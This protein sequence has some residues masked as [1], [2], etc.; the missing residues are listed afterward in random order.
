MD[1]IYVEYI[2]NTKV[3]INCP[4][5]IRKELTAEYSFYIPNHK[6]HPLVK[7][8]RW[9]G[10]IYLFN[11][12]QSTL[13]VGLVPDLVKLVSSRGYD[14]ELSTE[15]ANCFNDDSITHEW[16]AKFISQIPTSDDGVKITARDYQLRMVYLAA[17]HKRTVFLSATATGK[18]ISQYLI[19]R[20][21]QTKFKDNILIIVPNVGLVEQLSGDFKNYSEFDEEWYSEDNVEKLYAAY[22]YK[23]NKQILISTW[24][25]LLPIAEDKNMIGWFD[26]FGAVICDEV[27]SAAGDSIQTIMKC[28]INAS[29]RIGLTGTLN[30]IESDEKTIKG[31]FGPIVQIQTAKQAM[32]AGHISQLEID[33]LELVYPLDQST[34][35]FDYQQ[36]LSYI[37]ADNRRNNFLLNLVKKLEG[38]TLILVARVNEHGKVLEELFKNNIKDR[39]VY[40]I[41]GEVKGQERDELRGII[42]QEEN[43]IT[44]GTYGCVQTGTNIKRIHNIIFASPSK[45][46]IRVLQTIGRGLRKAEDKFVC[47]LF[48]IIDNF[49][50]SESNYCL[51]HSNDRFDIYAEQEFNFRLLKI[52]L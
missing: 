31:A 7:A 42:E 13:P 51:E 30:G 28:C 37:F 49:G 47:K 18:S 3:H 46:V 34:E 36:E 26:Q 25:S 6:F 21:L 15:V 33:C 19:A 17:K 41:H 14:I 16:F 8:R 9:N 5:D 45:S 23:G 22:Q 38:N 1:K 20:Y 35:K 11:A 10:K 2:N 40:F 12:K 24:Q 48:D 43:A 27:H 44:I 39:N 4:E 32:D 29:Y 50:H 52:P